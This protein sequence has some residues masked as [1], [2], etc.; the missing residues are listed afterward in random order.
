MSLDHLTARVTLTST[1]QEVKVAGLAIVA[2]E[3]RVVTNYETTGAN[4]CK[5][6]GWIFTSIYYAV[7]VT[8]CPS[9]LYR[10]TC[11]IDANYLMQ[12]K[13]QYCTSGVIKQTN[14]S[15]NGNLEANDKNDM[16]K[17]FCNLERCECL[18]RCGL[19]T[20]ASGRCCCFSFAVSSAG[21]A[22]RWCRPVAPRNTAATANTHSHYVV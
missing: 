22:A 10:N 9:K 6:I 2:A 12:N 16:N 20:A 4:Q 15:N 3:R 18:P 5:A 11:R 17:R 21:T 14:Q 13:R 8:Y 1:Q 19:S 7:V